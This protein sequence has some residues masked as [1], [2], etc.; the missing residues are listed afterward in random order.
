L[1]RHVRREESWLTDPVGE[2]EQA[3][4]GEWSLPLLFSDVIDVDALPAEHRDALIRQRLYWMR[5]GD[6]IRLQSSTDLHPLWRRQR[7]SDHGR[8]IWVYEESGPSRWRVRIT[9]PARDE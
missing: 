8:G 2:P 5:P 3:N 6:A 1:D 9:A 4:V 7:A